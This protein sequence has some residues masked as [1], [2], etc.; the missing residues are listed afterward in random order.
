MSKGIQTLDRLGVA[1]ERGTK[2]FFGHTSHSVKITPDE[3]KR[4]SFNNNCKRHPLK[5]CFS[6]SVGTG[7]RHYKH[8]RSGDVSAPAT[9]RVFTPG[10]QYQVSAP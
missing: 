5:L 3:I 8:N 2:P 4:V 6:H 7:Y 9:Y 1:R 10:Q